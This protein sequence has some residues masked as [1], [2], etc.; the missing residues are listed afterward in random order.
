MEF[1]RPRLY[2]HP[3][4]IASLAVERLYEGEFG[5]FFGHVRAPENQALLS[6]EAYVHKYKESPVEQVPI[7]RRAL[8]VSRF[9]RPVRRLMWW[10]GL[11]LS[12]PGRAR[13]LGTFGLSTYSSLGAQSLH[14]LSPL[15]T[16]L[17]YGPVNEEGTV[18][19]RIVYDHRVMDGSTVARALAALEEV[20]NGEL[21]REMTRPSTSGH[22][23]VLK[24]AS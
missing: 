22:R 21:L 14:P 16:I 13:R 7:F 2:E 18:N 4:S 8:R 5:V 20:F 19:V 17:N 15:S 3:F 24:E 6:L 12:G 9:P 10:Y 11:H 23:D 1:P